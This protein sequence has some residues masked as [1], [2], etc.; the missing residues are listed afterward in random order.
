MDHLVPPVGPPQFV[1]SFDELLYGEMC[2]VRGG[3]YTGREFDSTAVLYVKGHAVWL[4]ARAP[5][6]SLSL[7]EKRK[8]KEH[9]HG[10]LDLELRRRGAWFVVHLAIV[11][12][13]LQ[14]GL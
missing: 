5:S 8:R 13:S 12:R 1:D 14:S 7:L 9:G 4:V 6:S 2:H 11:L 10:G 3:F